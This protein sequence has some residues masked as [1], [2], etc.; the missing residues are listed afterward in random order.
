M[1]ISG[2]LEPLSPLYVIETR[3]VRIKKEGIFHLFWIGKKD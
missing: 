3:L 1:Q 2:V